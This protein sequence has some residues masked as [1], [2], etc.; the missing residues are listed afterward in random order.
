MALTKTQ[1]AMLDATG[2]PSSSTFLRG[3]GSWNAPPQ[4]KQLQSI[5]ASVASNTLTISASALTLDFRS[6]TATDGAATTISGTPSN[7]V[8]PA[9]QAYNV[10]TSGVTNRYAVLC[11][12]NAGT[13]VLGLSILSGGVKLD[14]TNFL[15]TTSTTL[16]TGTTIYSTVTAS[17]LAYRVIGF[18]D[19]AY[20]S[21]TGYNVAP[22]L[23]QGYGGNAL[24]SMASLGYGQTWQA[25]TRTGGTTYYNTTGKPI[26]LNFCSG[27]G[28]SVT[29][30]GLANFGGGTQVHTYIIPAGASYVL[31]ATPTV[32]T[33]ELR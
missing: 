3:D 33:S 2:T 17:N 8:V 24:N 20:T 32:N 31:N 26:L 29:I 9:N 15:S 12:N 22:T 10:G 1:V 5:S 30:A 18:I 14:E 11:L 4:S 16:N 19:I 13:L 27:T 25:V 28:V 23:V 7:L 6:T 21:G